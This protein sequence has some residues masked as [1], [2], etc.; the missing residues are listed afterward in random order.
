M[1][2]AKILQKE[3]G[4]CLIT[5]EDLYPLAPSEVCRYQFISYKNALES[6][7]NLSFLITYIMF[8]II[9]IF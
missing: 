7:I 3:T 5:L 2:L 8:I 4:I 1:T 6:R 9:Y